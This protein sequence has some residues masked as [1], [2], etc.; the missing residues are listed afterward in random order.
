MLQF[1]PDDQEDRQVHQILRRLMAATP[2]GSALVI[3]HW[4]DSAGGGRLHDIARW[5]NT[6]ADPPI[7]LRTREQITA[8]FDD[9]VLLRPGVVPVS[10]WPAQPYEDEMA[11][12]DQLC[13][14]GIKIDSARY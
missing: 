8:L 1:L 2:A 12:D 13:G 9:T 5:W 6:V 10:A 11:A 4:D 3:T 14:V 7:T